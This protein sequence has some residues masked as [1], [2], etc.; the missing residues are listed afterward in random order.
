MGGPLGMSRAKQ[1]LGRA[2]HGTDKFVRARSAQ[3]VGRAGDVRRTAVNTS[4][5]RSSKKLDPYQDAIAEYNGAFTAMN[6]KGLSLL[7][8]RERSTDLIELVEQL[9]NS[10]AKTPKAFATAFKEI[11][12]RKTKF[13]DAKE[14]ARKDL[15]A[16]RRSAGRAGAGLTAGAAIATMTPTAAM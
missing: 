4:G 16:A 12:A 5:K 2:V 1:G 10:I 8:E 15:E 6:D 13:V 11:D 7:R 3:I 14:F 9:V